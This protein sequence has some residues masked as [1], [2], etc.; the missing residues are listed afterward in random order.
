MCISG[1]RILRRG[2]EKG[3][4]TGSALDRSASD[5]V[6]GTLGRI[7]EV[8]GVRDE[9]AKLMKVRPAGGRVLRVRCAG[10]RRERALDLTGLMARSKHFMPLLD[11]PETFDKV[12]VVEGGLG[13][14]G[15]GAR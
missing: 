9:I 10:A 8:T 7:P 4:E 14:A 15:A 12:K 5:G 11:D 2:T 1:V 3:H 6:A 13:V